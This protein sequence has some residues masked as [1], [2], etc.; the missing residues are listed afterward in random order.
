MKEYTHQINID[1]AIDSRLPG[2]LL[3]DN[4]ND[5]IKSNKIIQ[6]GIKRFFGGFGHKTYLFDLGRYSFALLLPDTLPKFN[7]VSI[8]RDDEDFAFIEGTFYDYP[9]LKK[10]NKELISTDLANKLLNIV[11]REEYGKLK[12]FN[13]RY[14][15]FIYIKELDRLVILTD[16]YG[17]NRVFIYNDPLHF[18]I[19][20]NVFT[21]STNPNLNITV[22]EESIAQIIHY[23]YPAYRGTEFNEI[24]LVLPSDILIRQ[25][26]KNTVLKY[27]Q[28][29]YRTREKSDRQYID[30][31][32]S[33]IDQ[34]FNETNNF[35]E[36]P[37]GIYLSKGKDSRLFLPFLER[38]NIPYLPFVFK[39]DTGIFDYPQ[40]REIAKLLDKDLH[41]MENHTIDR[42]FSFLTSMN[43]TPTTPW[44]ALGKIAG[45]YVSNALMGLYGESS[46]GKLCAHRNY[47]VCDQETSIVATILG[48]SRG[49][50]SEEAN[51]CV[52]Y[53]KKWDTEAAFR[54]IYEDYPKVDIPFDYDTYQDI[55]HRSFRNAI[56][57]LVKAQHYITPLTPFMDKRIA[58]VYHRLPYSL[59]KSQLAHTIIA[60]EEPK[61]NK[62]KSTAF[63]VSLK[64]EPS[65]RP[66]LVELVKFNSKYKDILLSFHKRN[67]NP[68]IDK[69]AFIPK[70][71]YFKEIFGENKK[72]HIDNPRILTRM[73]NIDD[74]LNM[75]YEGN[76]MPYFK[77]PLVV[78]D[79]L[80]KVNS[81]IV[82]TITN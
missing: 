75:T 45:N 19:T 4:S 40:V 54:Q 67:Y 35:L 53:Y 1:P 79:E 51:R 48:N 47:G 73:Y 30:E 5:T 23:E 60:A 16:S 2:Y 8:A 68:Y 66:L 31:L 7:L 34:F 57:V 39:E 78:V 36:E 17:A 29:V 77:T 21:I 38:N 24:E 56:V 61:S 25:N 15:G 76:L 49:I 26:S 80:D 50:T 14:S 81:G 10:N 59:L 42:Y 20:N 52:P 55:D 27:Y 9:L 11:R 70:S 64:N 58:N 13:G 37:M 74:Y 46:S 41:V 63:P 18:T 12:E 62:V 71:S 28:S 44:L 72:V 33:T 69:D 32:R 22:N 6:E 43:T 65:F 82:S 3:T